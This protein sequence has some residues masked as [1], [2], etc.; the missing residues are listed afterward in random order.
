MDVSV[1][2]FG[3]EFELQV[4]MLA[5]IQSN[6]LKNRLLGSFMATSWAEEV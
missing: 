5:T 2:A 1:N 3:E 4:L 6:S